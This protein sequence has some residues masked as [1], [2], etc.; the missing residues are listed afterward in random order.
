MHDDCPQQADI[1][2]QSALLP[3]SQNRDAAVARTTK[4]CAELQTVRSRLAEL[5]VQVLCVSHQN[6][7]LAS[8]ALQL[9][10][11]MTDQTPEKG[12]NTKS[13]SELTTLESQV[14]VSQYRWK[15][16]KGVTSA[17]VAGS[18]VDWAREERFK[19]LVLDSS[20]C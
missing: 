15:V 12:G 19:E 3:I 11:R 14:K 16:M 18:G 8:E 10:G 2:D 5:E 6:A 7:K 4:T 17:I 1:R 20:D 13:Q 9:A